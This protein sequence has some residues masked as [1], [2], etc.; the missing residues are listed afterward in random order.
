M[1]AAAAYGLFFYCSAAAIT[2]AVL[3]SVAVTT[4]VAVVAFFQS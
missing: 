1:V 2:E 4:A 3:D